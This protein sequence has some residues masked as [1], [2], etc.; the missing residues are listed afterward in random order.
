VRG[1]WRADPALGTKA[2][3][4]A[5][6]L[7]AGLSFTRWET[8]SSENAAPGDITGIAPERLLKEEIFQAYYTEAPRIVV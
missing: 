7:W 5:V 6:D 4:Q 1:Q 3:Q 8:S 2:A